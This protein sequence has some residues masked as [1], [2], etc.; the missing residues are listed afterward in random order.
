MMK[1]GIAAAV[2]LVVGLVIGYVLGRNAAERQW[3]QPYAQISSEA[4]K[5]ASSAKDAD[6]TPPAGTKVLTPMPMGRARLALA[7]L[8]KQDP[9]VAPVASFGADDEGF[10]LH[11][12][13]ENKGKCTIKELSGVA[14]AFDPRGHAA[15]ANAGGET[16]VAFTHKGEIAPGKKETVA[17]KLKNAS[18]ATLA[19]AQ[20]DRTT[21]ADGTTW[22][23]P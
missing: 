23:R 3:S 9:A 10:E 22:A 12:V 1:I 14:Y 18:E 2:A 11:V 20:I 7:E 15:K 8:T 5:A 6:P 16:Y 13:V 4:E 21:C 17:A 19:L